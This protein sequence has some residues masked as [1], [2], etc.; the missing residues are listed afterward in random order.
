[1]PLVRFLLLLGCLGCLLPFGQAQKTGSKARA[2]EYV[3]KAKALYAEAQYEAS[4]QEFQFAAAIYRRLKD[5][6][7]Y[8]HCY[9]GVGNNYIE[10]TRYQEADNEFKRGL[11]LFDDLARSDS[12]LQ[13]DSLIIA[14]GYE[15]LGRYRMNAEVDFWKAL[16]LHQKALAIRLKWNA[17]REELAQS[18]YF[19]GR[20]Y[21]QLNKQAQDSSSL[22]DPLSMEADY[23]DQAL[24]SLAKESYLT[25][26]VYEALGEHYYYRKQDFP[27]GFDYHQKALAI[28]EKLF[29]KE[30]PKIASSYLQLAVYYRLTNRFEEEE[31]ALEKALKIQLKTLNKV[32]KDIGRSYYLLGQRNFYSGDYDQAL[33][34][35]ERSLRIYLE[36]VGR[37]S[38]EVA[39]LYKAI[40][41]AQRGLGNS[42]EEYIHLKK[43]LVLEREIYGVEHPNLG[44]IYI[45]LG[46]YFKAK[47][48]PDSLLF[49]YQKAAKLWEQQLNEND[50]RLAQAY[51]RLA[52]AYRFI[53]DAKQEYYYLNE[54]LKKKIS[55]R[56]G[57][58][59]A[60]TNYSNFGQEQEVALLFDS[61]EEEE[62]NEVIGGSLFDSYLN[63]ASFYERK[64]DYKLALIYVQNALTA[65][66]K[67]LPEDKVD[68]YQN[69]K[70]SCLVHN[71]DWLPALAQKGHLLL[72]LHRAN[73][74]PKEIQ[75]S[76][77]T[78]ALALNLVDSLRL[79]FSSDGSKQQ[80]T[81]RSISVYE[82]AIE[83][84]HLRY[85]Q[86]KN[87]TYLYQAFEIMERS[88]SFV[89][90]QALQGVA[91][92]SFSDLPSELLVQEESLRRKLAYYSDYRHRNMNRAEEFDEAYFQSRKSYDSL[93][94]YI[95]QNY[96]KYYQ[97]KYESPTVSLPELQK[98]ILGAKDLLLEY[99]IGDRYLYVFKITKDF[100]SFY[101]LPLPQDFDQNLQDLRQA[102]TDYQMIGKDHKKAY[103]NYVL[104]AHAFY[105]SY[106][107]PFIQGSNEQLNR[108]IVIPDGALSYIPFE[109]LLEEPA[110]LNKVDYKNLAYL[111]RRYQLN[112]S[113]SASL[114]V[115]NIQAKRLE[116]NRKCLGFAPAYPLG[117]PLIGEHTELPWAE[118]ELKAIQS[119]FSGQYFMKQEADKE[120]FYKYAS[121]YGLIHLA[122]HGVVDIRHPHK[123]LLLFARDSGEVDNLD[124]GRLY[125]YEIHN[126]DL[127]AD[128][129]VLSA[130][131]TGFGKVVRG[132]GV[133]SLAR[134][135]MYAGV[136][137]VVTT[138][139]K[140]ND[141]TSAALMAR[142]YENLADGMSKPA[143]LQKAKLDYLEQ[144]DHISGHPAFWG[145]FISIGNPAPLDYGW[146]WSSI[147]LLLLGLSL[148]LGA[149]GFLLYRRQQKK[150]IAWL[151]SLIERWQKWRS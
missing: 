81:K 133:L 111:I 34:Y 46:E 137:S 45:E 9:N 78:Y 17:P 130:C 50:Y 114:L 7:G 23:L 102:L 3:E 145:S 54:A 67:E 72:E 110:D 55:I 8:G 68:I 63:L 59:M 101:Q 124:A 118:E 100:P 89:L 106:V 146:S 65:V 134:A 138:L 60:K 43:S 129:V 91:A 112:Y 127:K 77:A 122:M 47:S 103:E 95:E 83:V 115:Q 10:L 66:C 26:D 142:F 73:K 131:E 136:P 14:D 92:R 97:L 53:R 32:H 2:L 87:P 11:A 143:A 71:I 56:D 94:Q 29:G 62:D 107:M 144:S 18:Y 139:W 116:N 79:N 21:G 74:A 52:E 105:K 76:E 6:E 132:E 98:E 35:Y 38:V 119:Y 41:K 148:V 69:P 150:P 44:Y 20:C 151:S 125:A 96:P 33:N 70:L 84:A 99:F 86:T 149:T 90:L 15:G 140:V 28:R 42:R 30:H 4:V 126:L 123:S 16:A 58:E 64:R 75:A 39:Q 121:N 25:A 37:K 109:V 147:L 24:N 36:L 51:D 82:G 141:Y 113:Y 93:V 19:I 120:N 85:Q 135:F 61:S 5:V 12:S 88:K 13:V 104:S 31:D 128:L 22:L 48:K 117:D 57:G 108:L 1:M 49:Y 27:K 40:A 80:L